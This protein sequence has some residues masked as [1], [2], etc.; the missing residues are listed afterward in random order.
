MDQKIFVFN[1][2]NSE[3]KFRGQFNRWRR[4]QHVSKSIIWG[5]ETETQEQH[6]DV[7]GVFL[8]TP[9][10]AGGLGVPVTP[11]MMGLWQSPGGGPG[12]KALGSSWDLVI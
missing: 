1:F 2:F 12:G 4:I 9:F 3:D 7:S 10:S 8:G 6:S 5:Y 11:P